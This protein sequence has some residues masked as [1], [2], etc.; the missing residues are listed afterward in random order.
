M[1]RVLIVGRSGTGKSTL[2]RELGARLDLPVV[3]LDRHYFH[4]DWQPVDPDAFAAAVA[5]FAAQDRWVIEGNYS[6]TMAPRIARADTVLILDR[7]R[8]LCLFSVV[9]RAW[10]HAGSVRADSA[11]GCPERLDP[12]FFWFVWNWRPD[13]IRRSLLPFKGRR[14]ELYGRRA[15]RR[16]VE[17]I[18]QRR[19]A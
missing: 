17:D 2:A 8:I 6:G 9:A 12:G 19:A 11:P 4:P 5:D 14:I 1:E 18:P 16:F 3:H 15:I 10:R 7:P 13:S